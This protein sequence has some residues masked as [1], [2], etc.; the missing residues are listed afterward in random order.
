[1]HSA[2]ALVLVI[3]GPLLGVAFVVWIVFRYL[4]ILRARDMTLHYR[5]ESEPSGR[6]LTD[7]TLAVNGIRTRRRATLVIGPDGLFVRA[8]I[9]SQPF[10]VPW[11]ELG[12]ARAS[13][14]LGRRAIELPIGQP[15]LGSI[16]VLPE[17]Y[18][19]MRPFL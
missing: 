7:V 14:I 17:A 18:E 13:R 9:P 10:L 3:G 12:T 4:R 5:A 6:R 15:E 16:R 19:A 11:S 8:S 2:I 1:M